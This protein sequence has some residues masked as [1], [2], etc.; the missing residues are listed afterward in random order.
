M[1]E[2]FIHKKKRKNKNT[3]RK[4]SLGG[5]DGQKK[6]VRFNISNTIYEEASAIHDESDSL[7]EPLSIY[8]NMSPPGELNEEIMVS[9]THSSLHVLAER[10]SSTGIVINNSE[11]P[12]SGTGVIVPG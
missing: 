6:K 12:G 9:S 4:N 8:S 5:E 1:S 3:R 2:L 10:R 11:G 7:I